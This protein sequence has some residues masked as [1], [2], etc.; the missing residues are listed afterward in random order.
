MSK[1]P[2]IDPHR[3]V[4]PSPGTPSSFPIVEPGTDGLDPVAASRVVKQR[5]V[6]RRAAAVLPVAKAATAARRSTPG[7]S[8]DPSS[9]TSE[10]GRSGRPGGGSGPRSSTT[11]STRSAST[12]KP[13]D[14]GVDVHMT[15]EEHH[16]YLR[17]LDSAIRQSDARAEE[18]SLAAD[19]WRRRRGRGRLPGQR[20]A[21]ET[22]R[23]AR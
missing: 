4:V 12:P 5:D 1:H 9:K 17:A 6:L 18:T 21:L 19:D 16:A 3:G 15:P 23:S 2:S 11:T 8:P 22:R 7:P 10:K 13:D 14:G 20:F